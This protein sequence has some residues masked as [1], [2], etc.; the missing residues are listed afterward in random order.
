MTCAVVIA[1]VNQTFNQC[2]VFFF[3]HIQ[4]HQKE[5]AIKRI[6]K[7]NLARSQ[8]LLKK[9]IK[10]LQELTELHHENVV[11]LLDCKETTQY[12]YL[13]MEFCN[14]GDLADYLNA[15]RGM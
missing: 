2:D 7:K 10:I 12:V 15:N 4:D 11:S 5:V 14:G 13:V 6:T 3:V 8:S 1:L 9:E